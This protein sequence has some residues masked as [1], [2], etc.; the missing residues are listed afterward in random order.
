M[1]QKIVKP[2]LLYLQKRIFDDK[3]IADVHD[4][5]NHN[6]NNNHNIKQSTLI[7]GVYGN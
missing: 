5:Y 7:Y 1:K 3:N 4:S 2:Y 6:N